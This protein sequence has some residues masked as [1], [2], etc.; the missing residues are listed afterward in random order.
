MFRKAF[1]LFLAVFFLSY[2]SLSAEQ[3][4]SYDPYAS[5]LK[6]SEVIQPEAIHEREEKQLYQRILEQPF[7]PLGY[8]LGKTAEWIERDHMDD[9]AKWFFDEMKTHGINPALRSPTEGG[10]GVLG[11]GG[12]IEL[13][14]LIP[15]DQPFD[16][17]DVFG[18]WTPNAQYA[19]TTVDAGGEYKIKTPFASTTHEGL[20]RYFRSSS[21]AFYGIG[22]NSS[23]G[24]WSVYQPEELRLEGSLTREFGQT[25]EGR[26]SF[27][28]QHMNIGNGNRERVGKIKE[29]FRTASIEGLDGGSLIGLKTAFSHDTRDH[30]DDPKAG[31]RRALEF[32]YFHDTDGKDFQYV[33]FGGQATQFFTLFSDRRVL[34]LRLVAEK[35]QELGGDQIPFFNLSRLG[36]ADPKDGSELL[37]S[38]RYNRFFGEGLLSANVEYRYSIYEYGNF[39]A[40]AVGLFDVGEIFQE[41]HDFGFDELNLSYGGGLNVKFHRKTIL[42]LSLAHGNEGSRFNI[43][44]KASF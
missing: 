9:K 43:H 26:A 18:G 28:Y 33:K 4:I 32:S 8:G 22:Q 7:R 23:L 2:P 20:I 12:R 34:G 39:S 15:V 10:F 37:R 1:L 29:H 24:E 16:Q 42:S 36:G 11:P 13:D 17:L 41:F 38:Y 40:D 3:E 6:H 19:G 30:Q 31:G 44:T 21:E 35:N 14:K 5:I 25:A 27:I